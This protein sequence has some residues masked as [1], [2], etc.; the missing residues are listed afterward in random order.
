MWSLFSLLQ[1]FNL[2]REVEGLSLEIFLIQT[3]E[4]LFHHECPLH[5][6]HLFFEEG[7][8]GNDFLAES[9]DMRDILFCFLE[10]LLAFLLF[11]VKN[12]KSECIF[13]HIA[14]LP[15]ACKENAV[16][17]ALGDD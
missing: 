11:V 2:K 6:L 5:F 13:N 16:S 14:A 4:F 1:S 12:F 15:Q 10:T 9:L 3:G 7:K 8:M 17:L